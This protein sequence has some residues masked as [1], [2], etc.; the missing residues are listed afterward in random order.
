MFFKKRNNGFDSVKLSADLSLRTA[1]VVHLTHNDFDAVG[2]DA[3]HRMRYKKEGVYTIF[4]SVGKFPHYLE[5]ISQVPGKG[6]ILSISDLAYRKGMDGHLR[7]IR[8]KGWTIEWRDHHRWNEEEINTT[9]TLVDQLHL[10]TSKCACGI[11]A[12][13]LMPDDVTSEE[14]A[15]VVCDYDLWKRKDP[16][17]EVL[18]LILQRPENRE[19]VRDLM[20]IGVFEDQ[21]IR[22][23]YEDILHEMN[24]A[25]ERT[26]KHSL[27]LGKK[28]RT[29][30]SP[31]YG[32]PSETAA[33]IRKELSSDIEIL[34]SDTGRFS[35][36]SV[37][38][39]SHLI[40][41]EFGGGGHPNAAGGNFK[42]SIIDKLTLKIL[43]HNKH[44]YIIAEIADTT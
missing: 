28:Y 7:K 23:E 17:S 34:V 35:I 10:D 16:R 14:I 39:V 20:M 21:K 37:P 2:A 30:V 25:M 24:N 12:K 26:K 43:K 32:Y 41:R 3:I 40:A 38:P 33:F 6:D 13:D 22:E 42:F 44:F 11:C 31:L 8:R 29:V 15:C 9:K 4:S 36:R 5:A 1:K 27:I 19:H 18:G